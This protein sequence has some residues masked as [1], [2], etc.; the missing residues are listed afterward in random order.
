MLMSPLVFS[1]KDMAVLPVL[2]DLFASSSS[3]AAAA[4]GVRSGHEDRLALADSFGFGGAHSPPRTPLPASFG[5]SMAAGLSKSDMMEDIDEYDVCDMDDGE[6]CSVTPQTSSAVLA[7]C[8]Q[9][10]I[11]LIEL[12]VRELVSLSR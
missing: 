4:M 2:N 9:L 12:E 1:A 11:I 3:S 6:V 7:C 5:F 10:A 8:L